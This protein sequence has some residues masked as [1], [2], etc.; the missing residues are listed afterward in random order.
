MEKHPRYS[1]VIDDS[2]E[3]KGEVLKL[4]ITHLNGEGLAEEM[5]HPSKNAPLARRRQESRSNS[6]VE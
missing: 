1:P 6:M 3:I 5:C 2:G 4:A